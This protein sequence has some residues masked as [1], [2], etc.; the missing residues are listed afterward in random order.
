MASE[1]GTKASSTVGHSVVNECQQI[2]VFIGNE[3]RT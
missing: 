2:L 1:D 3:K